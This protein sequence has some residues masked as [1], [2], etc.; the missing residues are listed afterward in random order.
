M[1]TTVELKPETQWETGSTDRTKDP[2]PF[3]Y[4]IPDTGEIFM[5]PF[6]PYLDKRNKIQGL[7]GYTIYTRKHGVCN[8]SGEAG[9]L[10]QKSG[11][12]LGLGLGG[13]TVYQLTKEDS[14]VING[15]KLMKYGGKD[16]DDTKLDWL[17]SVHKP[18]DEQG[19]L[20]RSMAPVDWVDSGES[21]EDGG[22]SPA[23]G[24]SAGGYAGNQ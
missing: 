16:T 4:I 6:G 3:E 20:R 14:T 22:M 19:N 7:V 5:C 10:A 2:C 23:A 8:V 12:N 24:G 15:V 11:F 17:I 21:S 13:N 1:S 18:N 9:L